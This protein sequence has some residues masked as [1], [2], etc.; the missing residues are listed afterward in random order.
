[1]TKTHKSESHQNGLTAMNCN[2]AV[3]IQSIKVGRFR[4]HLHQMSCLITLFISTI[5]AMSFINLHLHTY[6]TY[7]ILYTSKITIKFSNFL[8]YD[9]RLYQMYVHTNGRIIQSIHIYYGFILWSRIVRAHLAC[10]KR[11]P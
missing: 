4:H 7:T 9:S 11:K 10:K 8:F 2:F 5:I 1:M 3:D 6:H